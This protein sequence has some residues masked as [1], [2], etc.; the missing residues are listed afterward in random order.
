MSQKLWKIEDGD[1]NVPIYSLVGSGSNPH[2]LYSNLGADQNICPELFNTNLRRLDGYHDPIL[3]GDGELMLLRSVEHVEGVD[4][5]NGCYTYKESDFHKPERLETLVLRQDT[6]WPET[7][8]DLS[9]IERD[10]E[11]FL[12]AGAAYERLG[13]AFRRSYLMFGPPGN[14]KTSIIRHLI[15]KHL[16]ECNVVWANKHVPSKRMIEA[17]RSGSSNGIV[18]LIFEDLNRILKEPETMSTMLSILDGEASFNRAVIFGTTNNPAELD[19]AISN[20]PGRFDRVLNIANPGKPERV[21]FFERMLNVE[22]QQTVIA[23]SDGLSIAAIQEVCLRHLSASL[24]LEDAIA[25]L[26]LHNEL[27]RREFRTQGK[28]GIG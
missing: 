15:K 23:Q 20:R 1:K 13:R 28:I 11:T 2:K 19:A 14:G 8:R 4:L 24:S 9:I 22:V 26:K 10:L 17:L 12:G 7:C 21:R 3:L 5:P 27:V 6:F 16:S 18:V 25:E